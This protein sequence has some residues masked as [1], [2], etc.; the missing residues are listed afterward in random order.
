MPVGLRRDRPRLLRSRRRRAG[1]RDVVDRSRRGRSAAPVR[2]PPRL[3]RHARGVGGPLAGGDRRHVGRARPRRPGGPRAGLGPPGGDLAATRLPAEARPSAAGPPGGV[4]SRWAP[5]PTRACRSPS[6]RRARWWSPAG[7]ATGPTPAAAAWTLADL[8]EEPAAGRDDGW[9]RVHLAPSPTELTSVAVGHGSGRIW[10]AG[11]VDARPVAWE[12]LQLPFR[13]LVRSAAV[14]MPRLELAPESCEPNGGRSV[15]LV[16]EAP[17]DQPVFVAATTRGNRLCWHDGSEWKAI[18]A[19]EGRLQAACLSGGAVHVLRGRLGVVG[20]RPDG[21][22]TTPA[23]GPRAAWQ[24][25]AARRCSWTRSW[26]VLRRRW[27]TSRDG[28]TAGGRRVRAVR[29][30]V[31]ADRCGA[32]GR[33]GRPGGGVEQLWCRRV[34]SGPAADGASGCGG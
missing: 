13:G 3:G 9:R 19:P 16:E 30:A 34:G 12:V 4:A 6:T 11:R 24:D 7:S 26:R 20:G 29:C 31:G 28:A 21:R 18:P 15:V 23:Y 14:T 22:L 25:H 2:R 33:G 10:V 17:G 1:R 5:S 32:G 27:R 8:D